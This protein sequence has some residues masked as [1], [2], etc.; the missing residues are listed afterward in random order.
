MLGCVAPSAGGVAA[1]SA[2][3]VAAVAVAV[4]VGVVGPR[5]RGVR[6]NDF[7]VRGWRWAVTVGRHYGCE[8]PWRPAKGKKLLSYASVIPSYNT[9]S[10][11]KKL[12]IF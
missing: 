1:T 11:H 6:R 4:H 5:V 7:V 3:T 12:H 10:F 9:R 2:A 8:R